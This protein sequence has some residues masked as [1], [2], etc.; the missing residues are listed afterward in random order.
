MHDLKPTLTNLTKRMKSES[1][2]T[3]T[4]DTPKMK[5]YLQFYSLHFGPQTET[6]LKLTKTK[7]TQD[8]LN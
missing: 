1:K 3:Q 8:L 4:T 7:M 2:M 6:M 5:S